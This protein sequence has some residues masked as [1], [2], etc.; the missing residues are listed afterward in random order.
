MNATED[1]VRASID[2]RWRPHPM[3]MPP[4][5]PR[6]IS[7]RRTSRRVAAVALVASFA[8]TAAV[9]GAGLR[10]PAH[11]PSDAS[12]APAPSPVWTYDDPSAW[13]VTAIDPSANADEQLA[14]PEQA[15]DGLVPRVIGTVDGV[16]FVLMTYHDNHR[17]VC[18]EL[19]TGSLDASRLDMAGPLC[20]KGWWVEIPQD[21][22]MLS[23]TSLDGSGDRQR[24]VMFAIVSAATDHVVVTT[25]DGS[26]AVLPVFLVEGSDVGF[27]F[28]FIPP[29]S[30][31]RVQAIGAGGEE[32]DSAALCFPANL[33]D[34]PDVSSGCT[35][36]PT[37]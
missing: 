15:H 33:I 11:R 10:S 8:V 30:E 13:P 29:G 1:R 7:L 37:D 14:F 4:G 3:P 6:A 19:N 28:V 12:S 21:R 18:G 25:D 9:V 27:A 22:A 16:P 31:G 23:I 26:R 34:A 2:S 5:T 24:Q 35:G 32:L 36:T 20:T 17:A